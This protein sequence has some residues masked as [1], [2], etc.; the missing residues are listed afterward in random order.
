ME[1]KP[2]IGVTT[3]SVKVVRDLTHHPVHGPA[4]DTKARVCGLGQGIQEVRQ[5]CLIRFGA[6]VLPHDHG[7]IAHFTIS[8]PAD[9][10]FVIPL[11]ETSS[12]TEF[13]SFSLEVALSAGGIHFLV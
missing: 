10:I 9:L 12:F 5:R 2:P 7:G 13:T 6:V 3:M 4:L 1:A 8:H 11:G